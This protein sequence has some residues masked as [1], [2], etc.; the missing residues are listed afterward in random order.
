MQGKRFQGG[1]A[2]AYA[3]NSGATTC[4]FSLTASIRNILL[5]TISVQSDL[6]GAVVTVQGSGTTLWQAK[7]GS[8]CV[9]ANFAGLSIDAANMQTISCLVTASSIGA[10]VAVCGTYRLL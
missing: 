2:F 5:E 10:Y 6:S 7:L 8:S 3:T 1:E 9:P 4:S